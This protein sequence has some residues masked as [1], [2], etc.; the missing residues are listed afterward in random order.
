MTWMERNMPLTVRAARR[1]RK[2]VIELRYLRAVE[3]VNRL[4]RKLQAAENKL[5]DGRI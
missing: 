3:K 2:N 4:Q 5:S 1:L